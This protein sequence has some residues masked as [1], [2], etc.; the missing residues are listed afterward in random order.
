MNDEDGIFSIRDSLPEEVK[1]NTVAMGKPPTDILI[2]IFIFIFMLLKNTI[3][4][5]LITDISYVQYTL[6]RAI[7]HRESVL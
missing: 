4:I 2:L 6:Y 5:S 1:K 3:E 7:V